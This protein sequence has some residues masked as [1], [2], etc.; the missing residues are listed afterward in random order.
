M[1]SQRKSTLPPMR[2]KGVVVRR[3]RGVDIV[4]NTRATGI[5]A[6]STG[7]VDRAFRRP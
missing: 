5:S 1:D 6:N 2:T 4:A 3:A 7:W